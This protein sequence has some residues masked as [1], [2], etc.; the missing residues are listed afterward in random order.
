MNGPC[1]GKDRSETLP[2]TSLFF[3]ELKREESMEIGEVE[4]RITIGMGSLC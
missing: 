1:S 3:F 4:T 2:I